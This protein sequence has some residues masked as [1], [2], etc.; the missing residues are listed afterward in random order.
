GLTDPRPSSAGTWWR[1]PQSPLRLG[2]RHLLRQDVR[3]A[4]PSREKPVGFG[5]VEERL[6]GGIEGKLPAQSV[7]H[8]VK[9]ETIGLL[10][11]FHARESLVRLLVV[12]EGAG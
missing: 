2:S 10:S 9:H 6:A 11:V 12:A 7:V 3:R 1:D 8:A 5:V 4:I